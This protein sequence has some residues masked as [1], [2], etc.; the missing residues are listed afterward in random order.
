MDLF[1]EAN[2][3]IVYQKHE[4]VGDNRMTENLSLKLK[5]EMT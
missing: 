3:I 2:I 5:G 4:L 1:S